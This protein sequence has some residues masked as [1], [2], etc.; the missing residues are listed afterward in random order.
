VRVARTLRIASLAVVGGLAFFVCAQVGLRWYVARKDEAL[1]PSPAA[2]ASMIDMANATVAS[3][4]VRHVYHLED[5]L[6]AVL[7]T[8]SYFALHH[9][10]SDIPRSVRTAFAKAVEEPT[11]S[12]ADV[13][14]PWE[15]TDVIRDPR[16]PRRRIT[17]VAVGGAFCLVFYEHGGIVRSSNVAAFRLS[18]D[19]AEPVWHAYIESSVTGPAVLRDA[20][21]KKMFRDASFF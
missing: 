6:K 10:V 21:D 18:G 20:I 1:S 15:A 11:F 7:N 2:I 4:D 17:T 9:R 3:K 19:P 8:P 14:S 5:D 12:M 13:G 16:L